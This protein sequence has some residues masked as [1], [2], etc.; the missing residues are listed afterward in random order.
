[1]EGAHADVES[2]HPGI[3]AFESCTLFF[4]DAFTMFLFLITHQLSKFRCSSNSLVAF[5][6]YVADRLKFEIVGSNS[7]LC[8]T[9][10]QRPYTLSHV[11]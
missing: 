7:A 5:F 10:C 3:Y 8:L 6:A 1:M 11:Q 2:L 4:E 9:L